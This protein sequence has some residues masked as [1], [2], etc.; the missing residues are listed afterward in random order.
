MPYSAGMLQRRMARPPSSFTMSRPSQEISPTVAKAV[1]ENAIVAPKSW[2]GWGV[3]NGLV[4]L[5]APNN[6]PVAAGGIKPNQPGKPG[7]KGKNAGI[8]KYLSADEDYQNTLADLQKNFQDY[9]GQ[10]ILN[11]SNLTADYGDTKTR[12]GNQEGVDF[13]RLQ[14]DSA[15]RGLFGSGL[16]EGDRQ[17]F[18]LDYQNQNN[19]ATTSFNRNMSQLLT[20]L[21]SSQTLYR[22]QM[23][24]AKL[25]ALRRRAERLGIRN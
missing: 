13:K 4:Q 14:A 11:R 10:N 8:A 1:N 7:G 25:S 19:D 16:Y 18:Q 17:N 5:N 3:P 15:A 23:K 12:L 22:Q 6:G 21:M 20:D 9:R 24:D 2:S